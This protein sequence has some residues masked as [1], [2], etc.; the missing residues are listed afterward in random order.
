MVSCADVKSNQ[1]DQLFP[2]KANNLKSFLITGEL[3]DVVSFFIKSRSMASEGFSSSIFALDTKFNQSY[4]FM[5][6][7]EQSQFLDCSLLE[8][9]EV[10]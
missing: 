10:S 5:D 8:E 3:H 9:E 6:G 1:G 7:D 4:K 2:Q